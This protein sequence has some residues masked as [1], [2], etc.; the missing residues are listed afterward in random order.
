[1]QIMTAAKNRMIVD[2]PKVCFYLMFAL[3]LVCVHHQL[4]AEET[5]PE[6]A[7]RRKSCPKIPGPPACCGKLNN[8]A[9]YQLIL[10]PHQK[11]RSS[12]PCQAIAFRREVVNKGFSISSTAPFRSFRLEP[13]IYEITLG[14]STN[15]KDNQ[16]QL[17]V[18]TEK[19]TFTPYAV[20]ADFITYV[21]VIE[22]F[23]PKFVRVV[24]TKGVR[25]PEGDGTR[26]AAYINFVR[27]D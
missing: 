13:G 8:F 24:T 4:T 26:L 21:K 17:R 27:L 18:G 23:T 1:M 3:S 25:F 6:D 9:S 7:M 20:A 11:G 22:V 10:L 16:V 14:I 15:A 12:S 2:M 19:F 5:T